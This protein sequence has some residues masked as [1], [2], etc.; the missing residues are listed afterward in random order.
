MKLN[1]LKFG[2]TGLCWLFGTTLLLAQQL[3]DQSEIKLNDLAAFNA[4]GKSWTIA[5]KVISDP[6]NENELKATKGSGI[7]VNITSNKMK[8]SDL[9]TN[10]VH[11]NIILELDYLMAKN[12]NSGIYLQGNYEVQLK[13][14]WGVLQPMSSD[15]GGIYERWDDARPEGSK[16][17]EGYAPRQNASKAPGLWQHLKIA[18]QAPKFDAT[19]KK[20]ANARVLAVE[21]NGVLVQ[22]NVEL[23]GPTGGAADKEKPLG[24]L[25]LQGDHGS[26]AFRNIK[27]SKLPEEQINV[28]NRGGGD[29]D[30]IYIDA[31]SNTM[32]RSFVN[33][34]PKL[35]AVHA[36]SV[37]SPLKTHYSYDLDNGLLLQG[38]HGE[39]IDA[40][41]MWDGRGNGTSRARGAV[42]SFVKKATPALAQL[43]TVQ[44]TWPA[45]STGSGFKTKGYIIDNEDRPQFKYNIYGAE[46]TDII[47]VS[48]D[49]KGLN[50]SINIDKTVP[51]LYVLLANASSI[52]ELAKGYYLVDGQSYYLELDKGAPKPIIRD[53][54]G[55]KEL[56]ILLDKQLNYSISF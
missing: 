2:T 8:G 30:P 38:W 53:A 29:A 18:F 37:G 25:R 1:Y 10:A 3:T 40:T 47:T 11:G 13:D 6:R 48:N 46:V 44:T 23:F 41:P 43:A 45:D 15:N 5:E 21:L 17:F 34:A 50:R 32:I 39:F 49:G 24:P 22:D 54:N 35:L 7:L 9:L 16:G 31:P 12:S 56:I 14:S 52:E 26:V 20:T 42:T 19:G 51:N 4:V 27:I 36:I 28:N 33:Y 55:G